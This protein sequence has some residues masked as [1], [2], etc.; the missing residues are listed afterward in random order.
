MLLVMKADQQSVFRPFIEARLAAIEK[1]LAALGN[2][3]EAIAP[4]VSIGR[5]SRLDSMQHQQMALAGKQRLEEERSRLVAAE[6]RIGEGTYGKCLICGNDISVDRLEY[7]PDAV[8][9]VPC[10][11]NKK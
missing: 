11:Q 4:D 10:V 3:T 7:Q 8:T 1:E 6:F 9:C 5:L 2:S